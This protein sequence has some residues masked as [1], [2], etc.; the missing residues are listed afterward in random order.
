LDLVMYSTAATAGVL[1]SRESG[2][3]PYLLVRVPSDL[4]FMSGFE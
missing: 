4:L 3:G 2:Y 1:R